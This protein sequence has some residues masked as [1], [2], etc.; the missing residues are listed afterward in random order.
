MITN[1]VTN[2]IIATIHNQWL[3]TMKTIKLPSTKEYPTIWQ[4]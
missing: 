2:T 4:E 3:V 1:E